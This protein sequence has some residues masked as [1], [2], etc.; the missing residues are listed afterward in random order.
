[1]LIKGGCSQLHK[2]GCDN[3]TDCNDGDACT[4]DVCVD[5]SCSNKLLPC[6]QCGLVSRVRVK[7]TTD[8]YP[9]ETSW[10]IK[11]DDRVIMSGGSYNKK[12]SSFSISKCFG[13][14]TYNFT[15]YDSWGDGMCCFSG[16]GRYMVKV[17]GDVLI[18]GGS[19]GDF[20][21]TI[22][23]V[24]ESPFQTTIPSIHP[25]LTIPSSTE[26]PSILHSTSSPTVTL[27]K[28]ETV[29]DFMCNI[30]TFYNQFCLILFSRN[31]V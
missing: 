7:I 19:F 13:H 10:E 6:D 2:S 9:G 12:Y 21:S 17:D 3:D 23:S 29:N 5:G 1:M 22:F 27:C 26:T 14:G 8:K 20:E 16:E 24:V 18:S 28:S 30:Y 4:S 11:E 25:I 31:L 15:I